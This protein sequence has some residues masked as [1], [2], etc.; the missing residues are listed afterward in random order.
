M[1]ETSTNFNWEGGEDKIASNVI[2]GVF[3]GGGG[4][5][6]GGGG[7]RAPPSVSSMNIIK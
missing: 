6:G 2:S 3:R 1:Q 7:A 4:G 5:G